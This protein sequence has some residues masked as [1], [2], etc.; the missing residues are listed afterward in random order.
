MLLDAGRLQDGETHLA[1]TARPPIARCSAGTADE[2]GAAAG[3][4][5]TVSTERGSIS[6]PLEI[7]DMP[8][9]V[10]WLPMNSPGSA[11]YS[12][13]ATTAGRK[14]RIERGGIS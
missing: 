12:Q 7:T 13:L 11:L 14:V 10:V 2:I 9:R 4:L 6:V 3:D 5:V 1:G 8:D